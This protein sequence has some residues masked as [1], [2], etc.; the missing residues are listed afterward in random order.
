MTYEE[1]AMDADDDWAVM[2]LG[3]RLGYEDVR[4]D[5]MSVDYTISLSQNVK[6]LVNRGVGHDSIVNIFVER[7]C[8]RG[9]GVRESA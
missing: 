5:R 7:G 9:R 1:S 4:G 3:K 6:S 8:G 2:A